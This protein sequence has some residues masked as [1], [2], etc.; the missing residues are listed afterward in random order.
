MAV[1]ALLAVIARSLVTFLIVGDSWMVSDLAVVTGEE[2]LDP[3]LPNEKVR[4]AVRIENA[5]LC[6]GIG[7]TGMSWRARLNE[8]DE[9]AP[10]GTSVEDGRVE[11]ELNRAD[12]AELS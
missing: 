12:E 8:I 6:P 5:G 1:E 7:G 11:E 2:V 3:L 9:S 4:P 10:V